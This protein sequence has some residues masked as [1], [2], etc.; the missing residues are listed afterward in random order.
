MSSTDPLIFVSPPVIQPPWPPSLLSL[1]L[2]H[3]V[4]PAKESLDKFVARCRSLDCHKVAEAL[5]HVLEAAEDDRRLLRTL[6]VGLGL[7]KSDIVG[8][9]RCLVV[10]EPTLQDLGADDDEKVASKAK[11]LLAAIQNPGEEADASARTARTGRSGAAVSA[12]A[13]ASLGI[14]LLSLDEVS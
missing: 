6:H 11:Q 3:Q 14:D 8:I 13:S 12:P 1:L 9:D 2:L 7:A 4:A 5:L 10:L